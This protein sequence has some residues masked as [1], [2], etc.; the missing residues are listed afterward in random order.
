MNQTASRFCFGLLLSVLAFSTAAAVRSS[1]WEA[2]YRKARDVNIHEGGPPA[3]L[4]IVKAA[5]QRAGNSDDQWV[6]ALRLYHA[7]LLAQQANLSEL[8]I[9]ERPLPPRLRATEVEIRRRNGLAMAL[10]FFAGRKAEA[11]KIAD[12]TVALAEKEIP[13]FAAD[14]YSLRGSLTGNEEDVRT[15]MRLATAARNQTLALRSE[16][17]LVRTFELKGR[18]GEAVEIGGRILP[19][20]EAA[21]L[22]DAFTVAGNIGSSYFWLGDFES[23]KEFF[24][25]AEQ[26]ARRIGTAND[27]A[28]WLDRLGDVHLASHDL[29][30]AEKWY[31]E[32]EAF[33]RQSEHRQL[34]RALSNLAQV[35]IRRGNLDVARKWIEEA[36]ALDTR[37]RDAEDVLRARVIR[38]SLNTTAGKYDLA[39]KEFEEVVAKTAMPTSRLQAEAGL[40]RLYRVQK[41]NEQAQRY[42]ALAVKTAVEERAAIKPDHRFAYFN[43]VE[44]L[45]DDYVD[46]LV[47]NGEVEKALE[48]TEQSRARTL[49]EGLGVTAPAKKLD[50]RAIAKR[51]NATI[52]S[53]WL[54]TRRSYVWTVTAAGVTIHQLPPA[55]ELERELDRYAKLLERGSLSECAPRGKKLFATLAAPAVRDVAQNSRV[56]VIADGKLHTLN[57]ETLVVPAPR[58]HWWIDDVVLTSASSLHLLG[59]PA[60]KRTAEP[61]LLLVGDT[62]RADPAFAPLPHAGAEMQKVAAHFRLRKVLRGADATPTAFLAA[63]PATFDVIH[64]VAHGIA[65]RTRPLDSAVILAKDESDRYKLF[66]RDIVDQRL[67]AHLVT[68]SS[69]HGAGTRAYAGEGLVGLAWAFLRAGAEQ[70]IAALWQ[71]DDAAAAKLMNLMYARI[72]AGQDPAVALRDAK[73]AL[74]RSGTSQQKPRY[75]APFIIYTGS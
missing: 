38:A 20:L 41:K 17:M 63:A 53:Y 7:E 42:F 23:S 43:S 33:S 66:A 15:A 5:L 27:R 74:I 18:Y 67:T 40:G 24:L 16:A 64:F 58:A 48:V 9:L 44:D 73:R 12:E 68:I 14:A 39:R 10:Y 71:V 25:R 62:P 55:A 60:E 21:K 70:V 4:Q 19:R 72:G 54:G 31:R 34:A 37:D 30:G 45:F 29:N 3:A 49:A 1:P 50:P 35:A 52:L 36:I 22:R 75:W 51:V 47:A 59:Q 46:F 32:A 11:L 56:I 57:F 28:V 26:A 65:T 2:E 13:A 61:A 8:A 69:C 6:I